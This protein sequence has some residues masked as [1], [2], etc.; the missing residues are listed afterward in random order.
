[1]W[2][3]EGGFSARTWLDI[4]QWKGRVKIIDIPH[5]TYCNLHALKPES[6]YKYT[7]ISLSP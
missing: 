2:N 3:Y 7:Y 5:A 6:H 1:M 4:G